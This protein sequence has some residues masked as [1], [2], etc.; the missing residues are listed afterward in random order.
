MNLDNLE[1]FIEVARAGNFTRAAQKMYLAQSSVTRRVQR[2]ESELG[3][4]LIDRE[5]TA[6][7]L[8]EHGRIVFREGV[9]VLD[10]IA[11]IEMDIRDKGS[12]ANGTV[13]VGFYGLLNCLDLVR[14]LK[15]YM[16]KHYPRIALEVFYGCVSELD[17]DI[18]SGRPDIL[19]AMGCE[20]PVF[21]FTRRIL[22]PRRPLVLVAQGHPF[23]SFQSVRLSQLR[24][25]PLAFWRRST[26]PGF[27]DAFIG[28]CAQAGFVPSIEETYAG[29]DSILMSVLSGEVVTVLFEGTQIQLPESIVP[30]PLVGAS[31]DVDV[32]FAY[33]DGAHSDGIAAVSQA[34]ESILS[35]NNLNRQ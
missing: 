7:A 23:A 15:D 35:E 17:G 5:A 31:L 30:I 27:Y 1:C 26:V 21:G 6:F 8:T 4:M 19:V 12:E 28:Q 34:F 13:S 9:E 22:L 18:A 24:D 11:A 20:L 33:R 10:K 25:V 3:T 14:L 29:E 16:G 2:L 32:A